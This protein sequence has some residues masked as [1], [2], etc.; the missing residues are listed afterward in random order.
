MPMNA[1]DCCFVS[2]DAPKHGDRIR[3]SNASCLNGSRL[4]FWILFNA[5][6]RDPRDIY[7][8]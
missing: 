1:P 4:S 3:A 5:S 7:R 8:T 2:E 6:L